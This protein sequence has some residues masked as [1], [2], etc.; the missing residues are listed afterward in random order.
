M[1][2]ER[3]R[4]PLD[5]FLAKSTFTQLLECLTPYFNMVDEYG[6]TNTR[7]QSVFV[8]LCTL[9]L[10]RGEAYFALRLEILF[11]SPDKEW[12]TVY[13]ALSPKQQN[14][15]SRRIDAGSVHCRDQHATSSSFSMSTCEGRLSS[16]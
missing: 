5:D 16:R 7:S 14:G 13:R 1:D 6:E 10:D 15:L 8:R 3:K 4:K 11:R 9:L 2:D 12:Y